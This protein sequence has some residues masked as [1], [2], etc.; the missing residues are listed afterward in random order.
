MFCVLKHSHALSGSGKMWEPRMKEK[1][2]AVLEKRETNRV[3][4]KRRGRHRK[5]TRGE[6]KRTMGEREIIRMWKGRR[7]KRL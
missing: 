4:P 3:Q 2:S 1:D 6:I 7:R 5:T